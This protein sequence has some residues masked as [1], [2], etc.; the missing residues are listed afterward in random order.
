MKIYNGKSSVLKKCLWQT[1]SLTGERYIEMWDT[2]ENIQVV[3]LRIHPV[4][5]C[6]ILEHSPAAK[7]FKNNLYKFILP[8]FAVMPIDPVYG[9]SFINIMIKCILLY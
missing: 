1:A 8:V 9:A 5:S 3:H 6:T 4:F 2:I 7:K